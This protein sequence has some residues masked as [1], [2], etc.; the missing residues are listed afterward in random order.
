MNRPLPIEHQL[1]EQCDERFTAESSTVQTGIEWCA[2]A[3]LAHV[4]GIFV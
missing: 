3:H 2:A 4:R 1:L